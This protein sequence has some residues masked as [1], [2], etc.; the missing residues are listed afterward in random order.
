MA[1]TARKAHLCLKYS[2]GAK[3]KK[4]AAFWKSWNINKNKELCCFFKKLVNL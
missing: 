4:I 1:Y 2:T 3:R